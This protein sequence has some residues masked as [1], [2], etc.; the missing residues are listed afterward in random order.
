MTQFRWLGEIGLDLHSK[1][2]YHRKMR[3]FFVDIGF[4]SSGIAKL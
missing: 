2:S 1:L 3:H 4:I